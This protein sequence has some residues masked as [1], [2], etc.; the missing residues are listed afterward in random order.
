MTYYLNWN[1]D[2]YR[3][4][5]AYCEEVYMK[6]LISYRVILNLVKNCVHLCTVVELEVDDIRVR[7]VGDSLEILCVDSEK[8]VLDTESIDVA[9]NLSCTTNSLYSCLVASFA[10]LAFEFN[11]LHCLK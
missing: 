4:G 2:G 11:V 9:R 1:L 7:S 6:S 10:N 8:H 3:L 5:L